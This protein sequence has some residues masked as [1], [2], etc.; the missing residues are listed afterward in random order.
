MICYTRHF[1]SCRRTWESNTGF[2]CRRQAGLL[3]SIKC[4]SCPTK[5]LP[6][7]RASRIQAVDS[8]MHVFAIFIYKMYSC[9]A[10]ELILSIIATPGAAAPF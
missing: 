2:G 5:Y 7:C 3:K 9:V 1:S 4:V 6:S 8:E 10:V